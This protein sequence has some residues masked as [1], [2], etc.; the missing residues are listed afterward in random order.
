MKSND[1][2]IVIVSGLGRCGSSLTMQ[3]LNAG[4]FSC[5]GKFPI[6]EHNNFAIESQKPLWLS[7]QQN[8]AAKI[9]LPNLF[10]FKKAN[11]TFIWLNRNPLDNAKS[12]AK[13]GLYNSII[14]KSIS[15]EK[16][17]KSIFKLYKQHKQQTQTNL[18]YISKHGKVSV[19][20]FEDLIIYPKE[21]AIK[22]C[23]IIGLELDINAMVETVQFRSVACLADMELELNLMRKRAVT[24]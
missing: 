15:R 24:K 19:L 9:L 20:S 11:Y 12:T 4:G 17:A 13:F 21:S 10:K 6:F 22:L 8:I 5:L 14:D 18:N 1:N 23:K 16:L 3:M 7:Q 2:Q